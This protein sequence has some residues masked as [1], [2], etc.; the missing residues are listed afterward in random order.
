MKHIT[1][2]WLS[3]MS[4]MGVNSA[5]ALES[6]VESVAMGCEKELTSFCNQV[7]PG[8]GRDLA[9]LYAHEDKISGQ[10]EFAVYEAAAQAER[11]IGAL[12]YLANECDEDL[13]T[14]CAAVEAGEGRIAKCLLDNQSKL[15]KGCAAAVEETDLKAE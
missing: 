13:D 2:F 15:T 4:L 14:H 3:I 9:C 7:T 5:S 8:E 6:L 1:V 12:T 10:C 11:F